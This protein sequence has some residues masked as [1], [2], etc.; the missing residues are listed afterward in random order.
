MAAVEADI[1]ARRARIRDEGPD[2]AAQI[3]DDPLWRG[4]PRNPPRDLSFIVG[5]ERIHASKV[6]RH[7][8]KYRRRKIDDG[9]IFITKIRPFAPL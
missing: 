4:G 9:R 7:R 5:R 8:R 3:R 6:Y 2:S 1:A